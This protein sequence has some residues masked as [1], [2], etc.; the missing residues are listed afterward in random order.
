MNAKIRKKVSTLNVAISFSPYKKVVLA[1]RGLGNFPKLFLLQRELNLYEL[2]IKSFQ[3]VLL[4][5]CLQVQIGMSPD[6]KPSEMLIT[7]C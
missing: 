4:F 1:S 6:L 3:V 7:K 2:E 5:L